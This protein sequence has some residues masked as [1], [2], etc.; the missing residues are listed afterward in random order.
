MEY[1][2]GICDED[3][4][5]MINLMDYINSHK[6]GGVSLVAFSSYQAIEEYL[7]KNYLD[8]I[9]ISWGVEYIKR[10]QEAY[11]GLVV[12]PLSCGDNPDSGAIGKFQSGEA[13]AYSILERL[14]V[15]LKPTPVTGKNFYAVYSP[16]G[17]CGKTALAKGL[18]ISRR[19]SLYISLEEFG[20]R[21]SLGEEILYHIV[22]ENKSIMELLD[23]IKPNQYGLREIKGILSYQDIRQLSKGNLEWLKVQLL[24]GGDYDMVIFDIGSAVLSELNALEVMDRIYVPI[25]EDEISSE[26][27]QA[28]KELLRREEYG[29]IAKRIMYVNVPECHYS[30]EAMQE[31]ISKGE[32]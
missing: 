11:A 10:L 13:I 31:F 5:Y 22:F 24:I 30:S 18:G 6:I 14:D 19:N 20:R 7:D 32:L 16:L 2:I 12:I 27:L 9:L 26:K 21:D 8:G 3:Y 1:R 25:L 15:S 29:G 23:K 4:H 17:R 28:F